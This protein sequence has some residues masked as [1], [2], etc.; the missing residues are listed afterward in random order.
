MFFQLDN[1]LNKEEVK[2][3]DINPKSNEQLNERMEVEH[4]NHSHR[5]YIG[6]GSA[7]YSTYH[8]YKSVF[9]VE[10]NKT[11]TIGNFIIILFF[12]CLTILLMLVHVLITQVIC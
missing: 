7:I 5:K 8:M 1:N 3:D 11:F 4:Q 9:V 2:K 12:L 6:S 10:S